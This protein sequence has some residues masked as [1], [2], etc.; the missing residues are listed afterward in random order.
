MKITIE[1]PEPDAEDEIIVRC[2]ELNDDLIKLL[3]QLKEG[4]NRITGYQ[5]KEIVQLLPKEIYYFEAVDNKVFAYCEQQIY[6][7]RLKLY[8]V[9][10]PDFIRVSKSVVLNLSKINSISPLFNGRFEAKLNNGEKII[11]SRQYIPD[12]KKALG[13][14]R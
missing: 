14:E 2:R 8:E 9:H 10:I 11:I 1:T 3:Y 7:V 6:D 13:I 12:L 4:Q 5:G